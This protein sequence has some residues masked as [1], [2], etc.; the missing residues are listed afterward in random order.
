[1][2]VEIGALYREHATGVWR[3]VRA[4]VPS[5]ADAEDVT[6]EVFTRAMRSRNRFDPMLGSEAA[7]VVGIARHAVADWWRRRRPEDPSPCVPEPATG[8]W[9]DPPAEQAARSDDAGH[10]LALLQV[11]SEREQEAVALRFGAE[12]SSP[13]IG[14]AMGI[15]PTAARMLIHRGVGKL[16]EVMD[17]D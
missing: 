9:S 6:S 10:L 14:T 4:R 16:R 8:S 3:Y 17:H 12:L 2:A 1:M 13:E 7:W 5:D 15:S 11:L